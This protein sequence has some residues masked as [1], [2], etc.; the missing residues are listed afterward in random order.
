MPPRSRKKA[1]QLASTLLESGGAITDQA[2]LDALRL[3]RFH[4][5]K[6][7]TNVMREE[8]KWVY[9]DTLGIVRSRDGR[10]CLTKATRDHPAFFRL[11]NT[12]VQDNKPAFLKDNFPYTSRA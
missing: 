9:S 4:K 12:W 8:Q 2:A 5:N 10:L 3:W 7:R 11:L 1:N 6:V